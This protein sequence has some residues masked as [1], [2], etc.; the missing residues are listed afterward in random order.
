MRHANQLHIEQVDDVA[1]VHLG[2]SALT[3]SDANLELRT[4]LL[5]FFAQ[6]NISKVVVSFQ[7]VQ[8]M[9]SETVNSMLRL[10][11]HVIANDG[12]IRFCNVSEDLQAV[13]AML[14]LDKNVFRIY[15]SSEAAL[16]GLSKK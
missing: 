8:R 13:L 12:E 5:D 7:N 14:K 2:S 3:R 6:T 4:Q 9:T 1:V 15:E 16:K 10:R 11:D